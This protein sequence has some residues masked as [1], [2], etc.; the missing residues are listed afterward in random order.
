MQIDEFTL[1]L[2]AFHKEF[3]IDV[4]PAGRRVKLVEEMCEFLEA[5]DFSTKEH[6]DDE[7]IDVLVC[8]L[9]NV[10]ARGIHNP[11]FACYLKLQR[12]AAKYREAKP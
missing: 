7:A 1:H 6:T 8:A 9:A 2:E 5:Y 11:L 12:T 4:T 10:I 3:N